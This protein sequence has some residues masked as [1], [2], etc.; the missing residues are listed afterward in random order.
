M[1]LNSLLLLQSFGAYFV[2]L[3]A[4]FG[5]SRTVLSGAF[6]MREVVHG[7]LGPVQG[8][9]FY[10]I[11][12]RAILRIGVL[13]FG[14]G[15][16]FLSQVHSVLT[17]YLT[18]FFVAMGSAL[19]MWGPVSTTI[20]NWF[21]R[22]RS[23]AA[24]IAL[25][26]FS[27]GGL[28]V[29]IIALSLTTFG[30]RPTAFGSGVVMLLIG[31]PLA[32]LFRQAPEQ[33]GYLPD[34]DIPGRTTSSSPSPTPQPQEEHSPKGQAPHNPITGREALKTPAFWL[35]S[36]SHA[37]GTMVVTSGI[38]HMIPHTVQRMGISVETAAVLVTVIAVTNSVGIV[39]GVYIGDYK[40]ARMG[41]FAGML[42]HSM[43][44]LILAYATTM[45]QA[46]AF[47]VLQGLSWGVRNPLNLQIR[48]EFFGRASYAKVF[49]LSQPI[50]M[51]GSMMG[52]LLMGAMADRLGD[53]R[54]AFTVLAA[55]TAL[56]SVL[57]LAARKP[58]TARP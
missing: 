5:W 45:P 50:L 6:S 31:L 22:K 52:P 43:A 35:I 54:L 11:G 47:A 8:W 53:Y 26:G 19:T 24:G 56:G 39:I 37:I 13:L 2:H 9:L 7:V 18:F 20:V 10:K 44:L 27:A 1:A 46:L 58:S 21:D 3:Q 30:W 49:G 57:I 51:T 23:R 36:G 14:L 55:L 40:D 38:V 17:F 29:P 33:Y 28:L 42:G 34:G 4:Q 15:F 32:Q 16:I 12:P 25:L 41:I 48:A